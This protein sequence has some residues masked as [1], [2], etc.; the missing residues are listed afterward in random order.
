MNAVAAGTA[1][2]PLAWGERSKFGCVPRD[3]SGT[4]RQPLWPSAFR[5]IE[6]LVTSAGRRN[7]LRPGTVAAFATLVRP[8]PCLGWSSSAASSP[9][10]CKFPRDRS[11]RVRSHV[12]GKRPGKA[13]LVADA[14]AD[15]ALLAESAG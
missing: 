3:R 10:R 15:A 12:F 13:H 4:W 11:C 7:V 9:T 6:Y 14:L 8:V 1:D 2:I 5:G